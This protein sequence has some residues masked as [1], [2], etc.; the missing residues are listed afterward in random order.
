MI[1]GIKELLMREETCFS[2]SEQTTS[3]TPLVSARQKVAESFVVLLIALILHAAKQDATKFDHAL[4]GEDNNFSCFMIA[5]IALPCRQEDNG[6]IKK[7]ASVVGQ[8]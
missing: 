6:Q 8:K 2:I 3:S 7:S 4:C 1:N 5:R